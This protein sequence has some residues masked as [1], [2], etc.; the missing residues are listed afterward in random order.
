MVAMGIHES[1]VDYRNLIHDLA[2]MYPFD[3]TEV[4]V[5]ELIANSLDAGA[6]RIQIDFDPSKKLLV[7]TDNG[8]GMSESDF[9][10]YHDFAAGLKVKGSG[11]GFAGLGAKISF[12]VADRVITETR[13]ASFAGGS[14]WYLQ[15]KKKLVWEDIPLSRLKGYGT[16]VEVWFRQDVK[17]TYSSYDDLVKLLQQHY[18][19]LLDSKFLN[20][21]ESIKCY[22]SNLRFIVNGHEIKPGKL[23]DDFSLEKVKE[24][25][26]QKAG[27]RFG[28]GVFGLAQ[29][30]YPLGHDMCGV[31]LCTHGKVVKADFF[32]QFPGSFGPRILGVVEVPELVKFLTTSKTD[33]TRA[34]K[35]KEFERLYDPIRQE[36]KSWLKDLGVQLPE[37][38]TSDEA[39]KLE[40]ELKK[41]MDEI[42]ELAELLGFYA[43]KDV[44]ELGE[45][46]P[47]TAN[48][49]EGTEETFP[50]GVGVK[51]AGPGPVDIGDQPGQALVEEPQGNEIAQPISRTAR[52]G[53]KISFIEAP[54]RTDL[55]WVE[56]NRI[57]INSGHPAYIKARSHS[58][59]LRLHNLF[60]IA[61]AVQRFLNSQV[62]TLDLTFTDRMM[63]AW[64]RR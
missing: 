52:R 9:E 54:H 46:G 43:R 60:S 37:V 47:I 24:I 35:H 53:P 15:S 5:V 58:A 12:N 49:Q 13:S 56:G 51:K 8:K 31:L 32:N 42:P 41:L 27:K 21:Y 14:N 36:F 22:S 7:V 57:F 38:A 50:V 28:Y 25:F 40:R 30:E 19:P 45:N 18:L 4:V 48:F 34:G 3:V 59:T 2:D 63:A 29:S 44:L 33:F 1:S 20:L 11:I 61:S 6:S 55:A 17:P 16:R 62:G 39:T 64:G 10:E 26:P 23:A